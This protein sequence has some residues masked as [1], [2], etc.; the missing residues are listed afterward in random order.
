MIPRWIVLRNAFGLQR[1]L[2]PTAF[3]RERAESVA[4]KVVMAR[5]S[6]APCAQRN[7]ERSRCAWHRLDEM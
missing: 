2:V 5:R 1:I 7:P 3:G 6:V 4:F